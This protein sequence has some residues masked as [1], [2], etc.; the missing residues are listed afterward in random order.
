MLGR[1]LENVKIS[2][3]ALHTLQPLNFW[4]CAFFPNLTRDFGESNLSTEDK[5][6]LLDHKL[7]VNVSTSAHVTSFLSTCLAAWCDN[8]ESC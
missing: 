4:S 3:D 5:T 1:S 2:L 6:F 8:A 7:D